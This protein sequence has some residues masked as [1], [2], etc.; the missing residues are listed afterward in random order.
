MSTFSCLNLSA[1]ACRETHAFNGSDQKLA[2]EEKRHSEGRLTLQVDLQGKRTCISSSAPCRS[3]VSCPCSACACGHATRRSEGGGGR[4]AD[5]TGGSGGC[6]IKHFDAVKSIAPDQANQAH[7]AS[8]AEKSDRAHDAKRAGRACS[9]ATRSSSAPSLAA[10]AAR[11]R[12]SLRSARL[13]TSELSALAARSRP[14]AQLRGARLALL[15]QPHLRI[16]PIS[17]V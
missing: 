1:R 6:C 3:R 13:C 7:K 10:S 9:R 5:G 17:T 8:K 16:R 14:R 11:R 2:E 4:E 12:P 15:P